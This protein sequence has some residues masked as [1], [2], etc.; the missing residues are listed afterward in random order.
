MKCVANA[1]D[2]KQNITRIS[3]VSVDLSAVKLLSLPAEKSV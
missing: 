3:E 2:K 1:Q